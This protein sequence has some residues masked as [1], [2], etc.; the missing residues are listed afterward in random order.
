MKKVLLAGVFAVVAMVATAA[1][2]ALPIRD[3]MAYG[4]ARA[5]L[6]AVGIK[7]IKVRR[8][9][10]NSFACRSHPGWCKRWPE[11]EDC[12]GAGV[13]LCNM[14]F[15][16]PSGRTLTVT[17]TGEGPPVVTGHRLSPR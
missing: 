8:T 7:P 9:E 12:T 11:L 17:V 3:G 10:D 2:A 5:R 6:K 14:L 15:R 1:D 16:M 13:A 4:T